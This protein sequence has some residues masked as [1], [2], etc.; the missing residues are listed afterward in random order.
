MHKLKTLTLL[1]L[2][3][4]LTLPFAACTGESEADEDA[5]TKLPTGDKVPDSL[6]GDWI[7]EDYITV[8]FNEDG[9]GGLTDL[10]TNTGDVF[11]YVYQADENA[12]V[13]LYLSDMT[14]ETW[15]IDSFTKNELIIDMQPRNGGKYIL[16]KTIFLLGDEIPSEMLGTWF[17]ADSSRIVFNEDGT[18]HY[19]YVGENTTTE[20]TGEWSAF[21][22]S[23]KFNFAYHM[24]TTFLEVVIGAE[25]FEW[26]VE[27]RTNKK[28]VFTDQDGTSHTCL[29]E[30]DPYAYPT[31]P[32]AEL[33]TGTWGW[34]GTKYYTLYADG[35][36]AVYDTD[37]NDVI[38]TYTT[39]LYDEEKQYLNMDTYGERFVT[40]LTEDYMIYTD[41]YNP[42]YLYIDFRDSDDW[43]IG[44]ATV[45][46]GK[47][48]H[49]Y[50]NGCE[51][52]YTFNE[53]GTGIHTDAYYGEE[54]SW[55]FTYSYDGKGV[56]TMSTTNKRNGRPED[57]EMY[58]DRLT[59]TRLIVGSTYSVTNDKTDNDAVEFY[60]R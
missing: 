32:D 4:F 56:I 39:W 52:T 20:T 48:W 23:F 59:D 51:A 15:D 60:G 35:T 55:T 49:T 7:C 33:L 36:L 9:T 19:Y 37:D 40:A 43:S 25:L 5:E 44:D 41:I 11:Q 38:N 8:T 53:D 21:L 2:T 50:E 1:F 14:K 54:A 28:L 58:L 22:S 45:L 6:I 46:T 12:I 16:E 17:M 26:N 18:G 42:D 29:R 10:T 27:T 13:V 34:A 47:T 57:V 31:K 24:T 3:L 30:W